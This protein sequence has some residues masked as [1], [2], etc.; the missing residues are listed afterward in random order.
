MLP[1]V[2]TAGKYVTRYWK[3]AK[4]LPMYFVAGQMDPGDFQDLHPL[5]NAWTEFM[6]DASFNNPTVALPQQGLGVVGRVFFSDHPGLG[7]QGLYP[8]CYGVRD[9]VGVGE[10]D[11]CEA[12][13]ASAFPVLWNVN[14]NDLTDFSE[15]LTKLLV[16]RAEVEVPYEYLT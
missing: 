2:A 14:I 5:L 4:E 16:R 10:L 13:G 9:D 1:V 3:N 12:P 15:E 11:E 6:N 7:L 8:G